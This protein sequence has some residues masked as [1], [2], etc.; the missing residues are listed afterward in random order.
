[1]STRTCESCG[2]EHA[3]ALARCPRC[4]AHPPSAARAI[5]LL[6]LLA[7]SP[8][9]L[10]EEP[11]PE[12]VAVYG[13]PPSYD[14]PQERPPPAVERDNLVALEASAMLGKL[15]PS[16][17]E[18]L[19]RLYAE[20]ETADE[21]RGPSMLLLT[22]AF[23][24]GDKPT[25]ERLATRHLREVEPTNADL[26]YKLALHHSRKGAEGAPSTI[27]WAGVALA[28]ADRWTGKT[29]AARTH[30]LHKLR[31]NAAT[32]L[33]E[34]AVAADRAESTDATRE[35]VTSSRAQARKLAEIWLD[36]AREL[37]NDELPPKALLEQLDAK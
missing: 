19:E 29:L 7:A 20:S 4:H 25:W 24:I 37:G 8:G 18:Q 22:Q 33:W 26:A 27:E 1:M 2:T 30:T 35:A 5:A 16:Q 21:R 31:A 36:A 6:G 23:S 14:M 15:S 34:A 10:A 12:P 3:L 13:P 17:I 11:Y 28:N 9:A 32:A